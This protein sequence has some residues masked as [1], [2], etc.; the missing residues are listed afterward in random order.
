MKKSLLS[1]LIICSFSMSDVEAK[2]DK[3]TKEE[4]RF[5]SSS[6]EANTEN[7]LMLFYSN[8]SPLDKVRAKSWKLTESEYG[9]YKML[10]DTTQRGIWTPSIDPITL[11]G[12]EARNELE[13]KR[14]ARL[15]NDIELARTKKDISFAA[16]QS[17][18]IRRLSPNSNAFTS[19]LD[20]R[21]E[22]RVN[23]NKVGSLSEGSP[24]TDSSWE[25]TM[26]VVY[27]DLMRDCNVLCFEQISKVLSK[28]R[29]E[30]F[31][32][33]AK[34]DDEIYSFAKTHS[35]PSEKVK[36]GVINLNYG[37]ESKIPLFP[38]AM[39]IQRM[40]GNENAE[41]VVL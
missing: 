3:T 4:V 22:R 20:Q 21:E 40:V 41:R 13:E 17:K 27:V 23:Y 29:I 11:L 19:Y 28:S 30:F 26:Y 34:S 10:L 32:V 33:N 9:R 24:I 15:F 2:N 18:D 36:S 35:I 39:M 16:A 12:V 6:S 1:I 5:V 31:F 38:S 7:E 25:S 37:D 8:L 14:F